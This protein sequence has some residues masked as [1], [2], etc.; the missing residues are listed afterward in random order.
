MGNKFYNGDTDMI[1]LH[2]VGSR[3]RELR[4]KKG[5]TQSEFAEVLS[6]SFQAVSNWER[7]V[8]PPDIENLLRIASYFGILVDTLLA[9]G[10]EDLYLGIDGGG[11]KTEFTVV[12]SSGHIIKHSITSGSNPNDIGYE[13][14]ERLI[15]DEVIKIVTSSPSLKGIF[16][17][18]AGMATGDYAE[19]LLT[20]LKRLCPQ[21][22][23]RVSSDA[24]NLFGLHD[25]AD[26][27]LIGGTGSVVFV[28][29]GEEYKRL[30][31]WGYLFDRAGSAYDIGRDAVCNA[32]E[33]EDGN[34]DR[35][36]LSLML[37]KRMNAST[38]WEHINSL[39]S[40]G[41]AYI[42]S[43]ATTVFEAYRSGDEAAIGIIDQNAKALAGL[44]NSAVRLYGVN[45]IA[46]VSGGLFEHHAYIMNKHIRAYS[47]TELKTSDL[48]PVYGA[49]K[50]ACMIASCKVA[51]NFYDN[52]KKTY[53]ELKK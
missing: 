4:Q 16:C 37:L 22:E 9:P 40:G 44:L 47:A 15:T 50:Q 20:A 45:P 7:G 38:M 5:L 3:I 36:L 29:D 23:I 14:T 8:T 13:N 42:A 11:T 10:G 35:S 24:F 31:G 39:Y 51:D 43:F 30:G 12:S 32:L 6:V 33:E 1:D 26:M 53:G 46:T 2:L 17:G 41:R 52:F 18:V 48:P 25:D 27:V 49:C 21:A 34:R 19:R 28:R